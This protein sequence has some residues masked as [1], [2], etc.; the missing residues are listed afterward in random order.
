MHGATR[1]GILSPCT[2][3][4]AARRPRQAGSRSWYFGAS[5]VTNRQRL[6]LGFYEQTNHENRFI[7]G[8][9]SRIVIDKGPFLPPTPLSSH[10]VCGDRHFHCV[11]PLSI[12]H[13]Q[14]LLSLSKL[15]CVCAHRHQIIYWDPNLCVHFTWFFHLLQVLLWDE[16]CYVKVLASSTPECDYKDSLT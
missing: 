3:G 15:G 11:F 2:V 5:A 7:H 6:N 14:P 4:C 16:L 9:G 8:K 1:V 10:A 12:H 13:H